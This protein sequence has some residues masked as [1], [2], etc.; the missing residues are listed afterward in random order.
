MGAPVGYCYWNPADK[1]T[2]GSLTNNNLTLTVNST[3]Q[4]GARANV[5]KTSGKWYW[6]ITLDD[7]RN[8]GGNTNFSMGVV[9][10]ATNMSS[11][12][13]GS[14]ANTAGLFNIVG[15]SY[16]SGNGASTSEVS[17]VAPATFDVF[18][19][20]LDC[21][22]N[23]ITVRKNNVNLSGVKTLATSAGTPLFP[24]IAMITYPSEPLKMTTNFGASAFVYTVP[25]GYSPITI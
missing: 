4:V 22:S 24:A 14:T 11:V 25:S 5:S 2:A 9:V 3:S 10:A 18:G 20:L 21:D 6:E 16:Q 7:Y 13:I 15:A 12:S 17:T 19:I 1:T 8:S 23:T